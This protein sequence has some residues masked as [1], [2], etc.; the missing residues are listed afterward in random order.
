VDMKKFAKCPRFVK[1]SFAK[2]TLSGRTFQIL[3]GPSLS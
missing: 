2:L 1:T 3:L